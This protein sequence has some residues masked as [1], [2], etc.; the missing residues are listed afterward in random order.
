MDTKSLKNAFLDALFPVFCLSCRKEGE[1]LC[2]NCLA[3]TEIPDFQV[4]PACEKQITDKGFLCR[5]CRNVKNS[6]LDG[7]IVS[8]SY[9]NPAVK[10]LIHTFKYRFVPDIAGPLSNLV[11]KVLIRNDSLLPDLVVPVPLHVK[12]LRWRGFNQSRL[13]AEQMSLKL[14]PPMKLEVSDLLERQRHSRPQMEIKNHQERLQNV[15]DIFFLARDAD[16]EKIRD[17]KILLVDD[18]C[19]TG[20][21]LRE[22]AKVLK[23]AGAKK[24]FA[25]VVARQTLKK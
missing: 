7:L 2:E 4:C 10:K 24:V 16:C 14:A 3:Q 17:K 6:A 20:A 18:I 15:R 9:E 13:L 5:T 8:V 11:V 12:R 22:C 19:T 23:S 21:T 25:A 1:W